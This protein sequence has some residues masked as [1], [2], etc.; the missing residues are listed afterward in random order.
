VLGTGLILSIEPW[1][2]IRSIEPNSLTPASIEKLLTQHDPAGQ[3]RAIAHRSYD[4][5]L[6]IGGR[7]SGKIVDT[8]TGQVQAGLSPLASALVTTRQVHEAL[9]FDLGWL[10]IASTIAML[11]LILLGILMGWP[12]FANSLSGWH[13][14][15][16]W[17]LLP[18]TLLSPLTGLLLAAGITLTGPPAASGPRGAPMTLLEAVRIVGQKHDLSS[19]IWLRPMGGQLR[20]RLVEQGEYRVYTVT[21]DGTVPTPRNWPRLWHEGNFAGVWSAAMNVAISFVMIGLMGT[22]VF[23]WLRRQFRKRA[24]TRQRTAPA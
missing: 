14:I 15:L 1:L 16:G 9:L 17:G 18:L 6:A 2:V 24:S 5:T 21:R 8:A 11:V 7:G 20:A 22:G 10:V 19:L 4:K 3:A 23:I 12:R 13:K